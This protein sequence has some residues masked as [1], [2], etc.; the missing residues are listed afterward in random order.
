MI[1]GF[2]SSLPSY[3]H[4]G[5][6]DRKSADKLVVQ[7]PD[8]RTT[9][10]E[11]PKINQRIRLDY[12]DAIPQRL[13]IDRTKRK[14]MKADPAAIGIDYSH[15]ENEFNDFDLQLLIPQ[16][17]STKGTGLAKGDVNG[18]GL[19]D[20]FVGNA[21]GSTAALYIQQDDGGF[22][23][24]NENL[25]LEESKYEDANAILVDTDGDGDLDLYVVS[26]G[27]D[28]DKSSPLLQDRLYVNNG[29]GIFSRT[30]GKLP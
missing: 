3:V 6:S 18:D 24:S 2:Q 16:K 30:I 25:W 21:A 15:V 19:E 29:K 27:Y 11:N 17:Q 14:R 10:V 22:N 20:F 23:K 13:S 7:W 26:A 8:G 4:F 28:L 12:S 1:R 5:L 9:E